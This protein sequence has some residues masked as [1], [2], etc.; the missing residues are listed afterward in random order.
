MLAGQ[1]PAVSQV[2]A[3]LD[4]SPAAQ[5]DAKTA[6]EALDAY[7]QALKLTKDAAFRARLDRETAYALNVLGRP[8]ED[9]PI[10]VGACVRLAHP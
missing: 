4:L 10:V 5:V 7:A 2:P 9:Y 6:R 8:D 1:G 3:A